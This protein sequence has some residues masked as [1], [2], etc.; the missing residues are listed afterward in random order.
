MAVYSCFFVRN[1]ISEEIEHCFNFKSRTVSYV[2]C[3]V[4]GISYPHRLTSRLRTCHV[5]T[6]KLFVKD[7]CFETASTPIE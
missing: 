7:L 6:C 2:N 3:V 1:A 4:S 5:C